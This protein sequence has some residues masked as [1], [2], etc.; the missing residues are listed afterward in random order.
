MGTHWQH[1]SAVLRLGTTLALGAALWTA[2]CSDTPEPKDPAASGAGN[3][4]SEPKKDA[5]KYG[6]TAEQAAQVLVKVGNTT[7]TVGDFAE[8]LGGQ[9]PYLRARYNSPERRR[10]F[11]DNMVRFELLALEADKRGYPKTPE[12]ERVRQQMMV[13]QMMQ[14]LFEKQGVKLS[15]IG[16]KEIEQY[17]AANKTEFDK[18]AQVRASHIMVKDKALAEKLLRELTAQPE[19]MQLFRRLAEQHN[20]EAATKSNA[21][22][23]RFF[24]AKR[25]DGETDEPARPEA[26]R[27]AAFSLQNVGDVFPELVKTDHGFHIVKLTAKREAMVRTLEDARRLI[28][29]RLWREKREHAIESFVAGLRA[30]AKIKESAELLAKLHVTESAAPQAPSQPR[31]GQRP[32]PPPASDAVKP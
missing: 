2:G 6:L 24:S 10:E 12:V 30:K 22:D 29:N 31:A 15:D 11:L 25:D 18:P 20:E 5:R 21:G 8:R 17:F 26:I 19:D 1:A 23:L 3:T 27:K 16:D 7:I 28:Q 13:Q 9:S 4:T 32:V 14:D